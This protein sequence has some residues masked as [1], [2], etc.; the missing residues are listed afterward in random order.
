ME[1]NSLESVPYYTDSN[2][3]VASL[4]YS[5]VTDETFSFEREFWGATYIDMDYVAEFI[6]KYNGFVQ[7]YEVAQFVTP[8]QIWV[9][10]DKLEDAKSEL[11]TKAFI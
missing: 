1:Y 9:S 8:F 11:L 3:L 10:D 5:L 6:E 4:G 2:A 7:I